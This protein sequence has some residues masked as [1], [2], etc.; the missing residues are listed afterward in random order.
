MRIDGSGREI[1]LSH[2]FMDI[3]V[4][5]LP[6]EGIEFYLNSWDADRLVFKLLDAVIKHLAPG[7]VN[8]DE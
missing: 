5:N 8:I 4:D 6:E 2:E 7:I 1:S 3:L